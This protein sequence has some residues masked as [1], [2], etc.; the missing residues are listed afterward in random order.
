MII[1]IFNFI[2][3]N[4]NFCLLDISYQHILTTIEGI[5]ETLT[6]T[7]TTEDGS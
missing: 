1:I 3:F 4:H 7:Y 5:K 2:S 6:N